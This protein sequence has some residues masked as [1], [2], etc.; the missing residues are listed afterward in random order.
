MAYSFGY[1]GNYTPSQVVTGVPTTSPGSTGSGSNLSPSCG[2]EGGTTS[3]P[4]SSNPRVGMNDMSGQLLDSS[5]AALSYPRLGGGMGLG[6]GMY[7]TSYPPSEQNPY[8][9]LAMDSSS[10][11]YGSLTGGYS[12]MKEGG[13]E[14]GWPSGGLSGGLTSAYYSYDHPSLAA[15]G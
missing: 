9:S 12:G 15:Y 3:S 13:G 14:M 8:P 11:F 7:G 10:A 2:V 5:L 1:S 6:G 4:L